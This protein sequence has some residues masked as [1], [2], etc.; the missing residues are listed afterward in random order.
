MTKTISTNKHSA[1]R[2]S[3]ETKNYKKPSMKQKKKHQKRSMPAEDHAPK[4]TTAKINR[5]ENPLIFPNKPPRLPNPVNRTHRKWDGGG[6]EGFT[7]GT[8]KTKKKRSFTASTDN[9]NRLGT[10]RGGKRGCIDGQTFVVGAEKGADEG[11][12][13]G[14][15]KEGREKSKRSERDMVFLHHKP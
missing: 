10:R 5:I 4:A 8:Q 12:A 1:S 13:A 9:R 14:R 15:G 6:V 2:I 11:A 7:L 3:E